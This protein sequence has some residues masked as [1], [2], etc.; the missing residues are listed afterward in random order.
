[1]SVIIRPR[2][3]ADLDACAAALRHVHHVDRY[4]AVWPADPAGWLAPPKLLAALV[5]DRDGTV[6]GHIGLGT[7]D[8]TPEVLRESAGAEAV[9]SVIRLYVL[10]AARR[11]GVG[12]RL[13][14]E[15]ARVAASWGQRAV[16]TVA[17]DSTAAITLYER[18]GWRQVHSGPGGWRTADGREARVHYYIGP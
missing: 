1:M 17:S 16:L 12:A 11:A 3:E 2:T 7:S 18:H 15:A 9:V 6:V 13:L 14:A 8:N 4:P 10:P 5:A